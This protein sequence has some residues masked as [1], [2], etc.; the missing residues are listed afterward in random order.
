MVR[1][2]CRDDLSASGYTFERAVDN[3]FPAQVCNRLGHYADPE[4][5]CDQARHRLVFG[6]F[7]RH[8]QVQPGAAKHADHCVVEL[9]RQVSRKQDDR[10]LRDDLNG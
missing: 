2:E 10:F 4:A 9:G 6:R 1:P 3:A 8:I 7:V 5:G